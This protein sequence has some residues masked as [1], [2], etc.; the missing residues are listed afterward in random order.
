MAGV[1]AKELEIYGSHGM[2]PT[3]YERIFEMIQ[4]GLLL[5][6]RLVSDTVNLER[7]ADLLTR[8]ASFPNSGMTI[9]DMTL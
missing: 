1:I 8:F 6:D 2:Q 9:I 5:P 7:G 3:G 4:C